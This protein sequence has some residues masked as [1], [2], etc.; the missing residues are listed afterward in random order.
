[1][2]FVLIW[3]EVTFRFSPPKDVATRYGFKKTAGDT[4]EIPFGIRISKMLLYDS[5]KY[6][7]L[8]I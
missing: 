6:V 1:M 2:V 5:S 7:T 4:V 8:K 3:E